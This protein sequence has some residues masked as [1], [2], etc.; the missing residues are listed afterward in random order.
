[1][2]LH[3]APTLLETAAWFMPCSLGAGLIAVA[4]VGACWFL[5]AVRGV[6]PSGQIENVKGTPKRKD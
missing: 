6:R 4:V 3:V 5:W 2:I 1:M